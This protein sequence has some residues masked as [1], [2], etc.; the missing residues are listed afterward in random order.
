M[1]STDPSP[2][3]RCR[4][5]VA[6]VD[7][8]GNLKPSP[9][10]TETATANGSLGRKPPGAPG[11]CHLTSCSHATTDALFDLVVQEPEELQLKGRREEAAVS[12]SFPGCLLKAELLTLSKNA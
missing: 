11:N 1:G 2:Q 12:E 5:H 7:D 6:G 9:G 3:H 8:V 4:R 10:V